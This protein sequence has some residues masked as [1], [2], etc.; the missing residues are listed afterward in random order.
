MTGGV[1]GGVPCL[2]L[3][4][5]YVMSHI[6]IVYFLPCHMLIKT[7]AYVTC[8][9]FLNPMSHVTKTHVALSS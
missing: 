4:L 1:D 5:E 3:I 8:H 9:Y 2:L 7:K 6:S